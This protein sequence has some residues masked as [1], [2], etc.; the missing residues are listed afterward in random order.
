MIHHDEVWVQ[1]ASLDNRNQITFTEEFLEIMGELGWEA[2]AF[3]GHLLG[4]WYDPFEHM[5]DYSSGEARVTADQ[6]GTFDRAGLREPQEVVE[7]WAEIWSQQDKFDEPA[8]KAG[9]GLD[10][11]VGWYRDVLRAKLVSIRLPRRLLVAY[12]EQVLARIGEVEAR[13]KP[14]S[15]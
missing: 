6:P 4:L 5:L 7:Y 14:P 8:H 1:I 15:E 13:L 10:L 3:A 9:T 2:K 11:D 12:K